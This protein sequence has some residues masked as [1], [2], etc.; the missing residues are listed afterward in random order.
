M[1]GKNILYIF[2]HALEIKAK[3]IVDATE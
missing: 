3:K 2:F 1:L